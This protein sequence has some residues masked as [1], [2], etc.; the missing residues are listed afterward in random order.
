MNK[1]KEKNSRNITTYTNTT[2]E[3][4][5]IPH[6]SEE[7]LVLDVQK[8]YK[9]IGNKTHM[10]I[11][12]MSKVIRPKYGSFE[13]RKFGYG[14]FVEFSKRHGL[15]VHPESVAV[16]LPVAVSLPTVVLKIPCPLETN[17]E[18]DML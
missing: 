1:A 8:Y 4:I 14:T 13:F 10:R 16:P 6:V 15:E 12:V 2:N 9:K 11:H 3:M 18:A 5:Y 17:K 7:E